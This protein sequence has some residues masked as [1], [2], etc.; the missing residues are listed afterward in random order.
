MANRA[1]DFTWN[2]RLGVDEEIARN[3]DNALVGAAT[4]RR[5]QFRSGGIGY[6]YADHGEITV[7]QFPNVGAAVKGNGE[8]AA[9]VRIGAKSA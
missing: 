1:L 4:G 3:A 2:I 7:R 8:P 9:C 5:R 6:V